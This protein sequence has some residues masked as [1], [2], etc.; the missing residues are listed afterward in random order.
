LEKDANS[1]WP[2]IHLCEVYNEPIFKACETQRLA[3]AIEDL[4]GE[5]RWSLKHRPPNGGGWPV[6]FAVGAARPWTVSSSGWHWDGMERKHFVNSPEQ[7]LL[8]LP[9]FSDVASHG[10]GTLIATGS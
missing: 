8:V 1:S 6:N 10:G 4:V 7:G 3:G 9:C 5:A 2:T